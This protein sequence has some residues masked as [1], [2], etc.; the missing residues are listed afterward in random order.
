MSDFT[1]AD[2]RSKERQLQ[3]ISKKIS[4][5]L[6]RERKINT[7]LSQLRKDRGGMGRSQQEISDLEKRLSE[8]LREH[9]RYERDKARIS[10]EL[11][12]LQKN[13]E[14]EASFY[15]GEEKRR[16]KQK[17]RKADLSY[18]ATVSVGAM[19]GAAAKSKRRQPVEKDK[20]S[21]N[22]CLEVLLKWILIFIVVGAIASTLQAKVAAEKKRLDGSRAIEIIIADKY[23]WPKKF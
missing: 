12:R 15:R 18:I 9:E 3:D 20:P 22:G 1:Q 13:L 5:C 11:D 7:R 19:V 2:I 14:W 16:Q 4:A 21:K 8:A 10:Q 17:K 23:N 6:E